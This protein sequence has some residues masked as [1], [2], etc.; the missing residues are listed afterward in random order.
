MAMDRSLVPSATAVGFAIVA[1]PLRSLNAVI[2]TFVGVA[3]PGPDP[4]P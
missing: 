3:M 4:I 1:P 2:S